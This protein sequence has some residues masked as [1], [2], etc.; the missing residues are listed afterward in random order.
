MSAATVTS[1]HEVLGRV[2]CGGCDTDTAL[3]HGPG[4]EVAAVIE[5]ATPVACK[6]CPWSGARGELQPVTGRVDVTCPRC[7]CPI[8]GDS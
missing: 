7:W 5:A 3:P 1:F 6:V 2:V 8:G 4:C